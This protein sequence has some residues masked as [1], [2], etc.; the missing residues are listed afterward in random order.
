MDVGLG[1]SS[2]GPALQSRYVFSE[3]IAIRGIVSTG[4]SRSMNQTEDGIDYNFKGN[5]GSVAILEDYHIMG[6][7]FL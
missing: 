5:I 7:N 3:N 6:G 4:L 2:L 1:F